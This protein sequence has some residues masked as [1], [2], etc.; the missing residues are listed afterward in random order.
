[1][2]PLCGR[3]EGWVRETTAGT[4]RTSLQLA[5]VRAHH[6]AAHLRDWS[7]A[8]SSW[9]ALGLDRP[10]H[11][12]SPAWMDI[13]PVRAALHPSPHGEATGS[14]MVAHRLSPGPHLTLKART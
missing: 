6:T 14:L 1:M 4:A 7:I 12:A 2:V 11:P 13:V 3:P 10:S 5:P 9:R 8:A